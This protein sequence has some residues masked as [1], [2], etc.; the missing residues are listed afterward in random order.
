M[1]IFSGYIEAYNTHHLRIMNV[2]SRNAKL[3]KCDFEE[4]EE[5]CVGIYKLWSENEKYQKLYPQFK[6]E[7]NAE[8]GYVAE[9]IYAKLDS[10][11]EIYH[12]EK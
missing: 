5:L 8:C 2:L 7:N 9:F 4:L 11:L 12:Y 10:I 6:I 1:Q 3:I